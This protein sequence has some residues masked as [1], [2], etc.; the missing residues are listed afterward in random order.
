MTHDTNEHHSEFKDSNKICAKCIVGKSDFASENLFFG[1]YATRFL[2]SCVFL[3]MAKQNFIIDS[4]GGV[5]GSVALKILAKPLDILA[6]W[7]L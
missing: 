6:G 3:T 5:A 1:S 2:G 7:C 4:E